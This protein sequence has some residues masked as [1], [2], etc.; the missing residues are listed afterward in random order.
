MTHDLL[1][2]SKEQLLPWM[3]GIHMPSHVAHNCPANYGED[4]ICVASCCAFLLTVPTCSSRLSCSLAARGAGIRTRG[5]RLARCGTAKHRRLVGAQR[6]CSIRLR[7]K[8]QRP[9]LRLWL[10]S[11]LRLQRRCCCPRKSQ[12]R[13]LLLC[14]ELTLSAQYDPQIAVLAAGTA[15][16]LVPAASQPWRSWMVLTMYRCELALWQ[17]DTSS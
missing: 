11:M 2:P 5:Q 16:E 3:S 7:C 14:T 12:R 8:P 15:C 13:V 10:R 4:L 17:K 6:P 9:R 1:Q